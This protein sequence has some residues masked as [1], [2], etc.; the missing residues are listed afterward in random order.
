MRRDERFDFV[1]H[2]QMDRLEMAISPVRRRL[3][4]HPIYGA[5][6]DLPRLQTFMKHH[7]FAV[8]DFMSLAKR[9]QMELTTTTLPWVPPRDPEVARLINEIILEE[10]TDEVRRHQHLSHYELYLLAMD[11]LGADSSAIRAVVAAVVAGR[12]PDDALD[13][14]PIAPSTAEFTRGTLHASQGGVHEVAATFLFGRE[15]VIPPMFQRLLWTLDRSD[16]IRLR[17]RRELGRLYDRLPQELERRVPDRWHRR[18]EA[19]TDDEND[20]RW[21]FRFYLRRH[22]ELDGGAH[23]PAARRLLGLVCG[24]DEQRWAEARAAAVDALEARIRFWDGVH[25]ELPGRP[26][27]TRFSSVAS[28]SLPSASSPPPPPS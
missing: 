16:P 11:E 4:D 28:A 19:L 1:P 9:L 23:G 6:T 22:I 15:D 5:V 27:A 2:E 24:R 26:N 12:H 18:L 25:A 3:L 7:A 8:W 10:E 17:L 21:H 20:P 14:C 13:A